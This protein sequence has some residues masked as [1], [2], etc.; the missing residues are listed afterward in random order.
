MGKMSIAYASE[1]GVISSFVQ[2]LKPET[3]NWTGMPTLQQNQLMVRA[4]PPNHPPI[5]TNT[6]PNQ[7][8]H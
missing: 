4:L 7:Y 6:H 8:T 2:R 5:H 1:G 3:C